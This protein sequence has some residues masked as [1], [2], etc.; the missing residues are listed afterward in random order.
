MSAG[1][2]MLLVLFWAYICVCTQWHIIW[3]FMKVQ[4]T[5]FMLSPTTLALCTSAT[6]Q[7]GVNTTGQISG[8]LTTIAS[9]WRSWHEQIDH[10]LHARMWLYTC[11]CRYACFP[12]TWIDPLML[13]C[14]VL[15]QDWLVH[16]CACT[17]PYLYEGNRH[18]SKGLQQAELARELTCSCFRKPP[19]AHLT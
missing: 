10:L 1:L 11:T 16:H 4:S 17:S 12:T 19:H 8:T 14:S 9:E 2:C 15:R 7:H 5:A 18:M 3:L 13:Y 6:T